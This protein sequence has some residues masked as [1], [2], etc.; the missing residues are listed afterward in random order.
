MSTS[1]RFWLKV[2][3]GSVNECW[4]WMGRLD[5]HGYGQ[6][7]DDDRKSIRA[8]QFSYREKRGS[9]PPSGI[10]L[11]H[12]CHPIDGS[13]VGGIGC[14]HRRCANPDHVEPVTRLENALRSVKAARRDARAVC[15]NGH[16]LTQANTYM[17]GESK[18][19]KVCRNE[20]VKRA[21]SRGKCKNG[22]R[23]YQDGKL[24]TIKSAAA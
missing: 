19:C 13:C 12:K 3:V 1:A 16:A 24:R 9:L 10:H 14:L 4:P 22:K 7:D 5:S 15:G 21:R 8:H 17:H 20:A 2:M 11:D 23:S 6:F 18:A